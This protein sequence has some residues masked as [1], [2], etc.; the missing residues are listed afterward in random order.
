MSSSVEQTQYNNPKPVVVN[1]VYIARN[2]GSRGILGIIRGIEPA[3][4]GLA[5]P[6]GYVDELESVEEAAAREFQEEVGI[7]T[8][9]SDWRLL[10]SAT[11]KANRVLIFCSLNVTML[12]RFVRYLKPNE[13]VLGFEVLDADSQLAFPLH[14]EALERYL[15]MYRFVTG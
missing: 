4:G 11:T 3:K 10:H 15:P 7:A 2:D 6:G 9:P 5:L 1:V 13:E 12:E 8:L 14:Q